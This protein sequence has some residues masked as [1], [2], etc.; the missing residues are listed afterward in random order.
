MHEQVLLF[1]F[2]C[3]KV[4]EYTTVSVPLLYYTM[5]I[6]ICYIIHIHAWEAASCDMIWFVTFRA[7]D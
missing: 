5:M 7:W 6:Y 4:L 3:Y 2:L 1:V